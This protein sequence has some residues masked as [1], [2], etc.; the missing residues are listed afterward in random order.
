MPYS[1]EQKSQ[2]AHN[3]TRSMPSQIVHMVCQLSIPTRTEAEHNLYSKMALVEQKIDRQ[4]NILEDI[5][6]NIDS[7]ESTSLLLDIRRKIDKKLKKESYA[8]PKYLKTPAAAAYIS[9]D[10]SFLTQKQGETF[11]EGV[12]YF[13]PA[14]SSILRWDIAALEHWMHTA[15]QEDENNE[16]LDKMFS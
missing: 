4:G 10:P 8:D 14:G 5:L 15:K 1:K 13:R 2:N 7:I 11:I 6:L 9:V 16:I 12:H 3:I